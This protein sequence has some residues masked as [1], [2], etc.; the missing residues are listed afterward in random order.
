VTLGAGAAA[1]AGALT[2]ELM[3]ASSEASAKDAT[4]QVEYKDHYDTMVSQRTTARVF[5]GVGGA[6][7]VTGGVLLAIDLGNASPKEKAARLAIAPAP[8]GA[9]GSLSGSF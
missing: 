2:F 5:L 1:L 8:G 9:V 4:T 3:R 7:V 6:L